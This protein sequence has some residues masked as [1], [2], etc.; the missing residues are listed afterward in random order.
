MKIAVMQPYIFPYIGYF[1]MVNA[2]DIFVFY[3]NVDYIQRGYINRNNLLSG[4]GKQYFTVPVKKSSLGTK[5]NEVV[6][7]DYGKWKVKFL[8][9]IKFT[10]S[11]APFFSDIYMILEQFLENKKYD[12]ISDFSAESVIMICNYLGMQNQFLFSSEIEGLNEINDKVEKLEHILNT[13]KASEI[14]LPPGS[15]ELY[16][17]WEPIKAKKRTLKSLEINY[18]QFN[19]QFVENLSVIDVLMFNEVEKV[20]S[21]IE[22]VNYQ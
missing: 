11:K 2:S 10:Y 9:Q 21:F 5:I 12:K 15:K 1:Q 13:Y 16:K 20:Q 6:I 14:I 8:K 7:S 22:K 19:F 3:D 17:N 4:D 18:K